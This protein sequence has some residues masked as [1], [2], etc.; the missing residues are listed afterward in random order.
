MLVRRP[1]TRE[2]PR[3]LL[4]VLACGCG[5]GER[6]AHNANNTALAGA[7]GAASLHVDERSSAAGTNV[8]AASGYGSNGGATLLPGT[9]G[10]ST[11]SILGVGGESAAP[12]GGG[13]DQPCTSVVVSASPMSPKPV[14]API[15]VTATASCPT[16]ASAE[17]RFK[18]RPNGQAVTE[19]RG[20][21][22][23]HRRGS[24]H[25]RR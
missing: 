12:V 11:D 24:A 18:A 4:A 15:T 20:G 5:N 2:V 7:A 22:R 17:Y 14:G 6:D 1:G 19:L 3:F 21:V 16:N 8:G 23:D 13:S 10:T 25:R 9:G